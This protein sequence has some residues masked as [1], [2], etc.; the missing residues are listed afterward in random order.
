MSFDFASAKATAR[1]VV[2]STFGV[3][4]FYTDD[5]INTF[6]ETRVRWHNRLARPVGGDMTDGGYADVIE[7]IDRIVLIPETVDGYPIE[8]RRNG[9]V[10]VPSLLE[11]EFILE[12][13]EPVTGPLEEAWAVTRK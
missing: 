11:A 2:H 5:V 10:R 9:V 7:G 6:V 1:R 13:K 8:L 12:H 4:A 3:Q